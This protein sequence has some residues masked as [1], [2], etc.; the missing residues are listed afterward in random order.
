MTSFLSS[1][2]ASDHADVRR[3]SRSRIAGMG[4]GGI[5]CG[6]GA[7]SAAGPIASRA[8]ALRLDGMT[9]TELRRVGGLGAAMPSF[10]VAIWP[11]RRRVWGDAWAAKD[12]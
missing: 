11:E 2:D 6:A 1:D 5:G 4:T 10:N 12:V 8:S 9:L 7:T 3:L